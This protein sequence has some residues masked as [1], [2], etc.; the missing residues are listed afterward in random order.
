MNTNNSKHK[1]AYINQVS[2]LSLNPK[3]FE[4]DLIYEK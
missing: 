3:K 1:Q 4:I 2:N